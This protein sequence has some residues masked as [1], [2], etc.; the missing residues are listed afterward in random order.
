VAAAV[1]ERTTTLIVQSVFAN[2]PVSGTSERKLSPSVLSIPVV[3]G[4]AP[5]ANAVGA[6]STSAAIAENRLAPCA[7]DP[8]GRAGR[9][10]LV[11]LRHR[12]LVTACCF[13]VLYA[14]VF[15]ATAY[16]FRV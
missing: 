2:T 11:G 9:D 4:N 3:P 10:R 14:K 1:T 16:P 12:Q 13:R 8:A 5:A 7:D 15:T 6:R